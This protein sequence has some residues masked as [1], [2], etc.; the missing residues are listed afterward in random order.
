[1]CAVLE[2]LGPVTVDLEPVKASNIE[3]QAFNLVSFG[4][5]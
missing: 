2:L 5:T 3:P 1:M 4:G